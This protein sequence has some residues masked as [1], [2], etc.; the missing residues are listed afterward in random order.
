MNQS[1]FLN[2]NKFAEVLLVLFAFSI[3]LSTTL[4]CGCMYLIVLLW[5]FSKGFSSRW[6]FY[7]NYPLIKPI[8]LLILVSFVGLFYSTGSEK[9]C[10]SSFCHIAK[11]SFIPILAYYLQDNQNKAKKYILV[12]FIAALLFTVICTFLKIYAHIPIG[13]RT[14]GYDVFKNHIVISYFM[15]VSLFIL[16]VWYTELKKYKLPIFFFM[17]LI[18]YYLIFLNLG[19]I[20]YVMLFSSFI[21]LAWRKYQHKGILWCSLIVSFVTVFSYY[22]SETFAR[23]ITEVYNESQL[24]FQGKTVSSIGARLEFMSNSVKIFLDNPIMGTGTGSF[25]SQ[26]EE[27]YQGRVHKIT[28]NPHNQYLNTAVELGLIGLLFLGWLFYRQ[29]QLTCQLKGVNLILAQ[30][31]L[32]SFFVG[33]FF[34]SWLRNFTEGHFYY[35]MTAYFIPPACQMAKV[36]SSNLQSPKHLSI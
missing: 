7:V 35:L 11:L 36:R 23:R 17:G 2:A 4:T 21:V 6:H 25:K 18:S 12:V 5:L 13:R 31:I 27:Y 9:E 34:N 1:S 22:S 28:N 32:L 20:G 14:Y 29:W 3:P 33:C 10:F 8:L 26:Y 24:Y 16:Y 19:R 30:S 15:A